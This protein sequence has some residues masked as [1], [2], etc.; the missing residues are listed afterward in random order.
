[1]NACVWLLAEGHVAEHIML[2]KLRV[3]IRI[4]RTA[5]TIA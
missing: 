4:A 2:A 5:A 3:E 1:M